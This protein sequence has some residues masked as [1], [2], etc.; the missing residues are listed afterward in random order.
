MSDH[1]PNRWAMRSRHAL[2]TCGMMYGYNLLHINVEVW[3]KP[4]IHQEQG[5]RLLLS[6][7][8]LPRLVQRRAGQ[9]C[10]PRAT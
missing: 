6:K 3:D 8:D 9:A 5:E 1:T 10:E 2:T 4:A 7:P